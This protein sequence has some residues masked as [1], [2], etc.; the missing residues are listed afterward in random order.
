VG[1]V[2]GSRRAALNGMGEGFGVLMFS[3]G[4]PGKGGFEEGERVC[5]GTHVH[6]RSGGRRKDGSFFSARL[7]TYPTSLCD[8][9]ADCIIKTAMRMTKTGSGPTGWR[10]SSVPTPRVTSW[11]RSANGSDKL[12]VTV[13]NEEA[14]R[15][16]GVVLTAQQA[17]FYLHVDDGVFMVA[18]GA[19]VKEDQ[20]ADSLVDLGANALEDVGFVV[21]DRVATRDLK[22]IIGYEVERRPARLRLPAVNGHLLRMAL[23]HL[24]RPLRICI[25]ALRSV[26]GIWI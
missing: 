6:G 10:Q 19:G 14:V 25:A 1:Y 8:F 24:A 2:T 22:T 13:L 4:N 23:R 18:A 17:G 9:I 12:A 7:A 21:N 20:V 16:N 5:D 3:M 11:S 26:T 15:G